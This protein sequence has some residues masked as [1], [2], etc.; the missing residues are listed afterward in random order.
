MATLKVPLKKEGLTFVELDA[1][2][3][4]SSHNRSLIISDETSFDRELPKLS[5]LQY[6]KNIE[7]PIS[8]SIIEKEGLKIINSL[9]P[10]Y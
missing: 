10:E 6:D 7:T 5:F 4:W 9:Y 8:M 1:S 2:I 3:G